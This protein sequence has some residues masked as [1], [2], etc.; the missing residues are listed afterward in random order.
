MF[1][2]IVIGA[3]PAG[4]TAGIYAAA[5]KLKTLVI[6]KELPASNTGEFDIIDFEFLRQQ[7][8]QYLKKNGKYL[9]L[10]NNTE[11]ISLEKNVVSFSVETKTGEIIYSKSVIIAAGNSDLV[12]DLLTYKAATSKIKV[13]ARMQTNIPGIFA[14][15]ATN[16]AGKKDL[17]AAA[18][19]GAKAALSAIEYLKKV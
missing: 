1:D 8:E 10:K 18:G 13:D 4:T 3:G 9:Q 14:I 16:D 2:V 6:T 7:F 11:I 5:G 15:G 12:F 19:E 17:L